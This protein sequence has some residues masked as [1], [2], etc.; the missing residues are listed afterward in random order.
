MLET[1]PLEDRTPEVVREEVADRLEEND[2]EL[3]AEALLDLVA[4]GVEG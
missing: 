2:E 4:D 3:Q 1:V